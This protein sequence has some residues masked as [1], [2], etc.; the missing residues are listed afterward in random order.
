VRLAESARSSRIFGNS[1]DQITVAQCTQERFG[2]AVTTG[3]ARFS[4]PGWFDSGQTCCPCP[5][6]GHDLWSFRKPYESAGK[7]YFYWA[8]VCASCKV[9][10]E[11]RQLDGEHRT[12]L[13]ASS[14]HRPVPVA[15]STHGEQLDSRSSGAPAATEA[16][17][18][19]GARVQEAS[20]V[21]SRALH[22]LHT[23]AKEADV[24]QALSGQA[25]VEAAEFAK[26]HADLFEEELARLALN[27]ESTAAALDEFVDYLTDKAPPVSKE[28]ARAHC[29]LL[30]DL[31]RRLR[32]YLV[33]KRALKES[34]EMSEWAE[35]LPSH[36]DAAREAELN[37]R[38]ASLNAS[39]I[40]PVCR[41]CRP[42]ARM[43]VVGGPDHWFWRCRAD[44]HGTR[45]LSSEHL[46]L[47]NL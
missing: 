13:Y 3:P 15:T 31:A 22:V 40:V 2:F 19:A 21:L 33:E 6:C 41:H 17:A 46:R 1:M 34:R 11:P 20:T 26:R 36:S 37:Q 28:E 18:E 43:H 23:C 38:I 39:A 9:A 7:T 29:A 27:R 47:L 42:A 24:V 8:I 32:P 35:R 4:T 14:K 10:L 5:E 30:G 45:F 25:F 16:D 12:L 44:N